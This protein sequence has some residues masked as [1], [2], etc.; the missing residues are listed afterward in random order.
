[1]MRPSRLA[2]SLAIV[3][4]SAVRAI[5]QTDA[6]ERGRTLAEAFVAGDTDLVWDAMTPAM[7]AAVGTGPA[8]LAA[9]RDAVA[10]DFG[11]ET[12]FIG[13]ELA[14]VADGVTVYNRTSRWSAVT[15][16]ILI[17]IGLDAGG[18]VATFLVQPL[19]TLA[20]SRFLDYQTQADLRL[21][22][23]GEW[24]V[25][26][27]GRTLERNYHAADRAQRFATDLLVVRDGV[28][29]AGDPARLES[30]FCWDQ[31][32]LAPAAGTVVAAVD[33]F[34]DN[35]IGQTDVANPT[36][37]HVV[38]DLGNGEFA[39]LAHLQSGSVA[40]APG[41]VVGP[42]DVLGRC[43]NSGNTSEPHLH[44]HL[45]TTPDLATGEGLPAMFQNYVAD[46]E[47][48]ARGEPEQGQLVAP[49]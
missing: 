11:T 8:D 16:P 47:P 43:G 30:Y 24:F 32:I 34:A 26:W 21:P 19:P 40:V 33:S 37:N 36:G 29:Y 18:G 48:V 49:G 12:E 6:L 39:F 41:D 42:G 7:R 22:F 31:P 44:V 25:Y 14:S 15:P 45:Q 5:A 17:Q 3:L 9:F 13:E 1:M 27:G 2:L 38:L 23:D 35:P 46:G 10:R 28:T 20:E 4:A